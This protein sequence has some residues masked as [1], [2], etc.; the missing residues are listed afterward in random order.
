MAR[1]KIELG[2][3]VECRVTGFRGIVTSRVE[4]INGCIQYCVRG[5]IKKDG[6]YPE[7]EY[8]DGEHLKV[9]GKGITIKRNESGAENSRPASRYSG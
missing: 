6:K 5:K 7:A 3:E 8:I 9:V 4:Y 2:V 1:E